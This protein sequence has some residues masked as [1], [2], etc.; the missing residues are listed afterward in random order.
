MYQPELSS[1]NWFDL[2]DSYCGLVPAVVSQNDLGLQIGDIISM[3]CFSEAGKVDIIIIGILREGA[4]ILDIKGADGEDISY[5]NLYMSYYYEIEEE[6]LF[7]MPQSR[8]EDHGVLVQVDGPVI[9]TYN[10]NV[11]EET[12]KHNDLMIKNMVVLSSINGEDLRKNSIKYIFSQMYTL[13]PILASVFILTIVSAVSVNAITTKR[14]LRSYAIYCI[15]GLEWRRCTLINFVSAVITATA[16]MSLGIIIL[17]IADKVGLLAN[18]TIKPDLICIA[19]CF[20]TA[21]VYSVISVILPA[22]IINSSTP[23]QILK[24]N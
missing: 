15:C 12:R 10:E 8:L 13:F 11:P 5:D 4:R 16:S 2:N 17:L 7:I 3:P 22:K 6:P 19:V 18:T 1:G 14:Q 9:L 21:L 20:L 24:S 23:N